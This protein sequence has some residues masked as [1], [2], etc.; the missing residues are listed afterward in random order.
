M[1][2]TPMSILPTQILCRMTYG[3]YT[4]LLSDPAS[5]AAASASAYLDETTDVTR[6]VL[7]AYHVRCAAVL[8][9]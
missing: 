2:S 5:L 9:R 7:F 3:R 6:D 4:A 8:P 1:A